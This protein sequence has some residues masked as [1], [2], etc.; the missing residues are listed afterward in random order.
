MK[1]PIGAPY[2]RCYCGKWERPKKRRLNTNF[3]ND[4]SNWMVSCEDCFQL[5]RE[6]YAERWADYYTDIQAGIDFAQRDF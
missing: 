2:I 4:E 3:V 6:Y 5:E 1:K